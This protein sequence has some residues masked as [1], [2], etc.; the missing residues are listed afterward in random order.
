M[1]LFSRAMRSELSRYGKRK[2]LSLDGSVAGISPTRYVG[3]LR[4]APV[5]G[6]SALPSAGLAAPR[7]IYD[8]SAF[9]DWPEQGYE[10]PAPWFDVQPKPTPPLR[11][12][13]P[14]R[15]LRP[16]AIHYE[17]SVMTPGLM[18]DLL[19]ALPG[20]AMPQEP[21]ALEHAVDGMPAFLGQEGPQLDFQEAVHEGFMAE[22]PMTEPMADETQPH[23]WYDANPMTQ[24][25]FNQAA[26]EVLEPDTAPE[27]MAEQPD[28]FAVMQPQYEQ[29]LDQSL[30]AMV[31]EPMP[32][33]DPYELQQRMYDEQM[34]YWMDPFMM[35]GFGSLG[36]GPLGPGPFGPMPGP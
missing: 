3:G 1:G 26:Q 22:Q 34:Q 20:G 36:P 29:Q 6:S 33:Q 28:P 25:M 15:P 31:Q 8:Q 7:S 13:G 11:M 2:K 32:E 17:D 4:P 23:A 18:E 21:M 14:P 27:P 9:Y 35:P 5:Y 16:T 19:E 12:Q 30:E 24:E 10:A